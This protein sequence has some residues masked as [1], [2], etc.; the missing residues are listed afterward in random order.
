[1]LPI[2][3]KSSTGVNFNP[4]RVYVS[5]EY[6]KVRRRGKKEAMPKFSFPQ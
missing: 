4:L 3:L 6:S 5:N 1:M 2:P